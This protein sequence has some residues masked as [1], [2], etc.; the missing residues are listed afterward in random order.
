MKPRALGLVNV[1]AASSSI[2]AY[3]STSTTIPEHSPQISSVPMSSRAHV[4]GSRLKKDAR[5]TWLINLRLLLALGLTGGTRR[6]V[7]NWN[8]HLG[9][10]R[11]AITE[12]RD[13]FRAAEIG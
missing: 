6:L 2:A 3:A 5:K 9:F 7:I 12:R 10:D 1:C 8:F 11:L 13:E 4:S